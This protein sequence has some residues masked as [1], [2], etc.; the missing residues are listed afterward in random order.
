MSQ[1]HNCVV[2][3]PLGPNNRFI[4]S[5]NNQHI[6]SL[7][8][9]TLQSLYPAMHDFNTYSFSKALT[10]SKGTNPS[11]CPV[12]DSVPKAVG[13]TIRLWSAYLYAHVMGD[14]T[15][16]TKISRSCVI[17]NNYPPSRVHFVAPVSYPN[18]PT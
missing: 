2:L 1:R 10:V 14:Q 6:S 7:V 13:S 17:R 4:L 12:Y 5:T 16:E 18:S 3:S 8:I 9:A 11:F 15:L